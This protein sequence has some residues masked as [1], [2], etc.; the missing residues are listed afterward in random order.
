[1]FYVP[2]PRTTC[3]LCWICCVPRPLWQ[4]GGCSCTTCSPCTTGCLF[5]C[6]PRLPRRRSCSC[7][8]C[9]PSGF[10]LLGRLYHVHRLPR[11]R[12][13]SVLYVLSS[14]VPPP[15]ARIW[16][17]RAPSL[18][19]RF[20][21]SSPAAWGSPWPGGVSC[22]SSSSSSPRSSRYPHPS[23]ATALQRSQCHISDRNPVGPSSCTFSSSKAL[24]S[25]FGH[26]VALPP[27]GTQ[28]DDPPHVDSPQAKH[29][30]P[31]HGGAGSPSGGVVMLPLHLPP[32]C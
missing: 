28:I 22:S 16:P 17:A 15:R 7:T 9:S 26:S 12:G 21:G 6:V 10:S 4:R 24:S 31:C 27:I 1:V 8:M 23:R 25:G 13:A 5:D 29:P 3:C 14:P 32:S 19:M 20:L 30:R 18:P 2:S 11:R